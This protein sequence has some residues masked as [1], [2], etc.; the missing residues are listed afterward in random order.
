[1]SR[2]TF[3]RVVQNFVFIFL[4]ASAHAADFPQKAIRLI[5]PFPAGGTSDIVARIVAERAAKSLGQNIIID[6]RAGAGG[7]IGMEAA[8]KAAPDGYTL[9]YCSIGTCAMNVGVYRE[10]LPY[11]PERDFAPV[12]L[13]GM[14]SNILVANNK[15]PAKNIAELVALAKSKPGGLTIASSGYGLSPHLCAELLRDFAGIDLTHVPYK[16]SAPAIADLEGG[17]I[18]LFFDNSPSIL[19]HIKSGS[20][21]ALAVTGTK[22]LPALPDVP[23]LQQTGFKEFLVE[24]W[25]GILA[26][27]KVP[28]AIL[29]KLNE[30]FNEAAKDPSVIARLRQSEMEVV[31]GP[32]E[33]LGALIH[34]E[35][36][37]WSQ[38]SRKHDIHLE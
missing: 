10:K 29:A 24:P 22:R 11:H 16:G 20:L 2:I 31:G 32:P 30:A 28:P 34:S 23:T 15:L 26:P 36:E 4:F 37:K 17:Q 3:W 35:I 33:K 19:P 18:D 27:A 1:V 25:F 8:A 7:N 5:V 12:M 9:G 6:N 21:R 14:I 38:I 13:I